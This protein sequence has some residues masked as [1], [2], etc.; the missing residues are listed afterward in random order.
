M[1]TYIPFIYFTIWLIIHLIN[2]KMRFGAGAMSL[3]WIDI[4]AFFSILLDSKNLYGQFGCNDYAISIEGV[5]LYCV[6]WTIVLTPIM[7]LD[8]KDYIITSHINKP[9]LFKYLCLFIISCMI[10][11]VIFADYHSFL[12]EKLASDSADNYADSLNVE[13]HRGGSQQFL[14][15]IPNIVSSFSPLYLLCWFIS[16]TICKQSKL[17]SILLLGSSM[18]AMLIGF[19]VGG[20]AL[21]LWWCVTF[22]MG[23][24]FFKQQLSTIQKKLVG[25]IFLSFAAIALIGMMI[26]TLSRFDDGGSQALDSIIGYAGQQVNNFCALIPYVD[27]AHLY[28]DRIF[29]LYQYVVKGEPYDMIQF[30]SFLSNLYP[31]RINVFFTLFGG[32]LIDTGIAGL[33]VFLIVYVFVS[34]KLIHSQQIS[35]N[36][37][38]LFIWNILFCIPVRGLFGWPFTTYNNSL[39]IFFSIGLF[40]LFNYTFKVGKNKSL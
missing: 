9:K 6:L 40:V 35:I 22:L 10:I 11:H 12:Q 36:I 16:I 31:I 39:Y 2:P 14:L 30:Y 20:R 29:P 34:K 27:F 32:L 5:L 37:A 19:A 13:T 33:I 4:S 24:Y 15:W 1:L 23:F 7:K 38:Q 26:I 3:V 8:S 17:I 18:I 21:L 25:I 28:P